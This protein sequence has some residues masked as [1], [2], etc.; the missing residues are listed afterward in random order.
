MQ[1]ALIAVL[2]I[3]NVITAV[4]LVASA[5][6]GSKNPFTQ[7]QPTQADKQVVLPSDAVKISECIPYE[8]EHYVQPSKVPHGPIYVINNGK[9]VGLEYM[10][11]P[12]E[13]PGEKEAKMSYGDAMKMVE[14]NGLKLADLVM[15]HKFEFD[16]LGAKVHSYA[17]NWSSAHSGLDKPHYDVHMYLVSK[18]EAMA[19]CPDA[20]LEDVYSPAVLDNIQRYSI[21]FPKQ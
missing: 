19:I 8:G 17:M 11:T 9:V 13:I 18:E 6:P 20:K 15:A 14:Q 12:D 16:V 5:N 2:V 7:T 3:T 4:A 10:F 21:P 1:K